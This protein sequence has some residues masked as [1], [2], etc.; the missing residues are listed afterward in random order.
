[1]TKDEFLK[2]EIY[3]WGEDYIFDLI[4]RGY[5]L[6]QTSAGWKWLLPL[7]QVDTA[8]AVC[9]ASGVGAR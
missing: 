8:G 1:M 3:V 5:S 7:A 2:H 6:T 9:Y 4:D